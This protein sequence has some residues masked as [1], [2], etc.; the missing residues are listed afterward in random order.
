MNKGKF[1]QVASVGIVLA[2][3]FG[4]SRESEP[5]EKK[6]EEKKITVSAQ[7]QSQAPVQT[8]SSHTADSR[9]RKITPEEQKYSNRPGNEFQFI[10]N[11]NAGKQTVWIDPDHTMLDNDEADGAVVLKPRGIFFVSI[12][13]Q[14]TPIK[15]E[16]QVASYTGL[17]PD[18]P[19]LLGVRGKG[20][21]IMPDHL[22]KGH[23][24]PLSELGQAVMKC[25]DQLEIP[26]P[27]PVAKPAPR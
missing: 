12:N 14:L 5:R 16:G 7:T 11:T 20:L 21:V 23:G 4:C 22:N 25:Y 26:R 9:Y 27:P 10:F 24:I 2:A 3:V 17:P 18:D 6:A 19:A 15:T 1:A 13:G 8:G